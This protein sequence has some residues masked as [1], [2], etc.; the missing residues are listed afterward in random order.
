MAVVTSNALGSNPRPENSQMMVDS[1]V[2]M[3]VFRSPVSRFSQGDR[4]SR[5]RLGMPTIQ[6]TMMGSDG[7]S[8]PRQA[9]NGR[10]SDATV[11]KI[12]M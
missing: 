4:Y 8:G 11:A 6:Q 2:T 12:G 9:S 10:G 3:R 5:R 1:R 7:A